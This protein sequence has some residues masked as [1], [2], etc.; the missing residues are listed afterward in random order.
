MKTEGVGICKA[1]TQTC[2]ESRTWR[3]CSG[4]KTPGL[5]DCTKPQ[6]EDCDGYSCSETVWAKLFG[7]TDSQAVRDSASDPMGNIVIVGDFAGS[8]TFDKTLV[9]SGMHDI[10]VA[11]LDKGGIP[12]WSK[13]FGDTAVAPRTIT[14]VAVDAAGNVLVAGYF[15]GSL[16]FDGKKITA[17]GAG[18]DA[19]VIKIDKDGAVI[20]TKQYGDSG[21]QEASDVAVDKQG[22]VLITGSNYGKINLGCGELTGT[23]VG[24][25]AKLAAADG[26]CLFS[27]PTSSS[28][29]VAMNGIGVD[30][31]SNVVVVGDEYN[32]ANQGML[33]VR[34]DS[35]GN[36]AWT[37]S[38]ASTGA[39]DHAQGV[40]VDITGAIYVIGTFENTLSFLGD[41]S[42]DLKSAGQ[43]DVALL[44][45]KA[46]DGSPVWTKRFGDIGSQAGRSI[47]VDGKGAVVFAGL[48]DSSIGFGGTTHMN[49]FVAPDAFVAKVMGD[50][51]FV[52]S[53]AFGGSLSDL[54]P[55][56]RVSIDDTIVFTAVTSG[57]VIDLGTGPLDVM[58]S[59]DA[60]VAKIAP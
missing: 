52:W 28:P 23:A 55:S 4:E 49:A 11:K 34:Y 2:D 20:W 25:V 12:I 41:P 56:V 38:Y 32:G 7:D 36:M 35:V 18:E 1:G 44:K 27:N 22:N 33:I 50:G 51:T 45:L 14:S 26:S 24:Y 15:Q 59:S 39:D 60:A 8:I 31:S 46:G 58:G 13:Q 43:Q 42:K 21:D 47:A 17:V 29:F 57:P 30:S 5:E 53:R 48:F 37:K 6:D 9:A 16:I 19:F 40:A 3:P 54:L 10:Y